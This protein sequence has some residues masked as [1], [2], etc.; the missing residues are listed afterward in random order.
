M[1]D[2]LRRWFG[3][4]RQAAATSDEKLLALERDVQSLRLD[5]EERERVIATLR[6]DLERLRRDELARLEEVRQGA[7]EQVLSEAA[8]AAAQLVTQ[9]HLLE[10]DGK[11]VSARDILTVARR[12]VR[13]LENH[14]LKLEGGIGERVPFDPQ[15]H[16][17]IGGQEFP[18]PGEPVILRM[19]CVSYRGKILY[20]GAVEK[21]G[22]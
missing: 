19:V 8:A 11:P 22:G 7:I 20:K 18:A 6:S 13:V 21:V 1:L 10:V 15:R 4:G 14:G 5:L 3:G 16:E 17:P 12:L 2:F 9:A